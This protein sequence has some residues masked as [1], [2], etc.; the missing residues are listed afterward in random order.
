[1]ALNANESSQLATLTDDVS[2]MA[3]TVDDL[4]V[5]LRTAGQGGA[6]DIATHNNSAA[7]HGSIVGRVDAMRVPL[8]AN[9]TIYLSATGKRRE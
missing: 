1:M 2:R 9:K 6:V 4:L 5:L 3:G 8:T 7:A